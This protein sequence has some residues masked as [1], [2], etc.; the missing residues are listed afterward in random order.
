MTVVMDMQ[1]T[2]DALAPLL[3]SDELAGWELDGN[4]LKKVY[5]NA[6]YKAALAFVVNIGELAEEQDHHPDVLLTWP[7]TTVW[8]WTHTTNGVTQKDVDAAKAVDQ[9]LIDAD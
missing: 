7:T 9:L 4:K 1:L 8:F 2:A 6:N 3:S 5:E